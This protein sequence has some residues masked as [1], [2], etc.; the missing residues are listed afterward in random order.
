[1]IQLRIGDGENYLSRKYVHL[2][3]TSEIYMVTTAMYPRT[4]TFKIADEIMETS[5]RKTQ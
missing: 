3:L 2:A 4:A 1:M 5:A